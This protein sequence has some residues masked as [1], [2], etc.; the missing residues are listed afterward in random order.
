MGAASA[1]PH[2]SKIRAAAIGA[3][4]RRFPTQVLTTAKAKPLKQADVIGF[5][6]PFFAVRKCGREV[7]A[8]GRAA[9]RR[10]SLRADRRRLT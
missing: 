6:S 8:F 4:F 2:S 5:V 9:F 7:T 10:R 1:L 3:P